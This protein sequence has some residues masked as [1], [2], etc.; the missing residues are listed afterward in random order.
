MNAKSEAFDR[1]N[2]VV[3]LWIEKENLIAFF[4]HGNQSS[5]TRRKVAI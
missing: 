5:C 2:H 3:K 4:I 1:G